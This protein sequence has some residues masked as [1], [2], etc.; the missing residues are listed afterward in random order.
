MK[1][2]EVVSIVLNNFVNDSRVLKEA[3][4]LKKAGYDVTVAAMHE[5]PL[6]EF[7]IVQGIPVYSIK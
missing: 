5:E 6:E 3:V 1:N 7:D 4:S 2:K